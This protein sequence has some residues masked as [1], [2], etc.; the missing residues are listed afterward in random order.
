MSPMGVALDR[1]IDVYNEFKADQPDSEW[2]WERNPN[3]PGFFWVELKIPGRPMYDGAG[4]S[5]DQ[6][7][8]NLLLT[9]FPVLVHDDPLLRM[10]VDDTAE[11]A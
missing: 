3:A 9:H 4:P 5:P 10:L 8:L 7:A 2:N 6:A 1:L 11:A